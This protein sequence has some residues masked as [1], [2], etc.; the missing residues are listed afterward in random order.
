MGLRS[1]HVGCGNVQRRLCRAPRI[2]SEAMG[3]RRR[4][5]I[6]LT[7]FSFWTAVPMFKTI[8]M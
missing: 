4:P 6:I 2:M 5:R 8:V 1:L 3:G 7:Y